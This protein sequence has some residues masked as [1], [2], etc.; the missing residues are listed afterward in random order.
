MAGKTVVLM[1][2]AAC[3]LAK[4]GSNIKKARLRRN[5]SAEILAEKAKISKSTLSAIEKG[6]STVSVG[7][8]A[9]VLFEL[10]LVKDFERIAADEEGKN[11]FLN[12]ECRV[13]RG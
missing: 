11:S 7:A 6:A 10:G 8:Y 5:I 12:M 1:P 13:E 9:S 2:G 4:M 3:V